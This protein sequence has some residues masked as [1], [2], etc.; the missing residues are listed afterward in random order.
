MEIL[1]AFISFVLL[2]GLRASTSPGPRLPA[3]VMTLR[4]TTRSMALRFLLVLKCELTSKLFVEGKSR[5]GVRSLIRGLRGGS[6]T[7]GQH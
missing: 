1:G 7:R 4:A 6:V 5:C 2:R 3:S